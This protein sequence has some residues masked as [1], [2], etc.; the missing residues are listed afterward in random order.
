[1]R[2]RPVNA[3]VL[4]A[5]GLAEMGVREIILVAQ[6][7]TVYGND[8]EGKALLPRLLLELGKIPDLRWIRLMYAHPSRISDEL[9]QTIRVVPNVLPYLD[10]PMQHVVPGILDAMNRG[11]KETPERLVE[12]VRKFLPDVV[13][14]TS[15]MVGF[16]GETTRDF[17]KLLRFI[18]RVRF[19]R[20]GVFG[21]SSEPGTAAHRA[22]PK[23]R[24]KTIARRKDEIMALQAELSFRKHQALLGTVQE[25]VVEE[26]SADGTGAKGRLWS[27]APEIDGEFTFRGKDLK[28]GEIIPVRIMKADTYDLGGDVCR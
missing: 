2:S 14:R 4:E 15:L 16:P 10:I 8:L 9:L 28:Q 12:R 27:Q 18:E 11:C 17:R 3:V 7:T 25:A 21:F 20:L 22:K 24:P 1:M 5:R 26:E 6:D 13:L 19:D 23:V